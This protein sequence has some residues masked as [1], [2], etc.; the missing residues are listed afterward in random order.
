MALEDDPLAHL[1][2]LVDCLQ[3]WDLYFVFSTLSRTPI[4]G[5]DV[6]LGVEE[7]RVVVEFQDEKRVEKVATD[8]NRALKDWDRIVVLP[9]KSVCGCRLHQNASTFL[10]CGLLPHGFCQILVR[11]LA[12]AMQP[13]QD[14]K[15][16]GN[17]APRFVAGTT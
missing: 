17:I 12:G 1:G 14:R 8:L 16:L 10:P 11:Y 15:R 4:Q 9:H 7:G 5:I 13:K 2:I 6:K 3:E